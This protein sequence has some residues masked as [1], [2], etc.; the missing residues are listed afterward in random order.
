MA[1]VAL[2]VLCVLNIVS[3]LLV[4]GMYKKR[5]EQLERQYISQQSEVRK[6]EHGGRAAESPLVV[7]ARGNRDL[8]VFRQAIPPK[9]ELTGLIGEVFSLAA[10]SGLKIDQIK[11]KPEQ[12]GDMRLLQ[13]GLSFNVTGNYSQVKKFTHKIEQSSRLLTID[14]MSLNSGQQGGEVDLKLNLTTFFR[15][16]PS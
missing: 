5:A 14:D 12:L 10:A 2:A 4:T 11:Y 3:Y 9:R 15:A 16:D 7:Y 8:K 13:Y 1:P 6:A